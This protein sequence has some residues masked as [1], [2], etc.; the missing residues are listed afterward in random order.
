MREDTEMHGVLAGVLYTVSI[1]VSS[2]YSHSHVLRMGVEWQGQMEAAWQEAS[3]THVACINAV[4]SA[5]GSV[6][7]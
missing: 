2:S 3:A 5:G 1:A 7:I 6:G 4:K